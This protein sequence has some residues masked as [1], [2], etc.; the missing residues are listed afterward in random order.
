VGEED[1][2]LKAEAF[3]TYYSYY[4]TWDFDAA[5]SV[6]TH[7]VKSSI[8]PAETGLDYAQTAT[9]EGG[10]LIF[11]VRS[12]SPGTETV[13]KKVW[14]RLRRRRTP[15]QRGRTGGEVP[16]CQK[17]PGYCCS[18]PR[19]AVTDN[20]LRRLAAHAGISETAARKR[21]TYRYK[22]GDVD[23]Q[24]MRHHKDEVYRSVC[25]LFDRETRKCTVY[26]L[27]PMYA[28]DIRT[29]VRADTTISS[30]RARPSGR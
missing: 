5:T 10:H 15:R 12:G 6:V 24:I 7:H 30:V 4:G 14:E 25:S 23:E 21:F 22:A 28:A 1:A 26:E 16:N 19:I 20:D 13:R 2:A 18:H 27:D 29:A 17:C 11:T 8:I 3:D 9:L